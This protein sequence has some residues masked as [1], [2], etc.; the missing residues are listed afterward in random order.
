MYKIIPSH[1]VVLYLGFYLSTD[2]SQRSQITEGSPYHQGP[3]RS[4]IT[5]VLGPPSPHIFLETSIEMHV[6]CLRGILWNGQNRSYPKMVPVPILAAKSG[7]PDHGCTFGCQ[8]QPLGAELP[9]YWA[10]SYAFG[11]KQ[12]KTGPWEA[13]L[14]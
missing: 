13:G 14:G 10:C 4:H 11:C 7:P 8:K 3:P 12:S 5:S 6:F 2:I 9:A 1:F